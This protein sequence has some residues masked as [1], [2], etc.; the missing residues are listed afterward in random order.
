[1]TGKVRIFVSSVQK[2]LEDE[3]V[4]V[5]HL[6]STDAFL[7]AHCEP[8]L[9]EYE[10]ASAEKASEECLERLDGCR[11][12]VVIVGQKQGARVGS[13]T[14]THME[15]QRAKKGGLP[16]L[17]FIRG[18]RHVSREDGA[19]ALLEEIESDGLKYKRFGNVV[20]LQREVRGSLVQ[21]LESRFGLSPSSDEDQVAEQTIA[22]TSVFESRPLDHVRWSDLDYGMTRRLVAEASAVEEMAL[23]EGEV[24]TGA[25]LRGLVWRAAATGEYYATAAG[26]LL[27]SDDPSAVFPQC[28]ILA[29]A[30]VGIQADS[31]PRDHED[32]REPIPRAVERAVE[33]VER[34]TRHPM[35][36][37]GLKRIRLDE[38]PPEAL[39][40]ALVNALVHRQYEDAGRKILLEV[41]ADKVV[42]SSPGLPPSPITLA[43]LRTGKYRPC[44]RNPVLAQG[45][46]YFQHIEERG[47]GFRRM[48]DRMLDHGLDTPIL[49]TDSGYFQ[50]T[51]LGPG[52]DIERLRTPEGVSVSPAIMASLNDRQRVI[53]E[54]VVESGDVTT[55]WCIE[56]FEVAR[57][58][59][60]RDLVDMVA[61]H[62]L[63]PTGS[64]RSVKYTLATADDD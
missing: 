1:M 22:A 35:R 18:E 37:V 51:L 40:E 43:A 30:Y 33:F 55:R 7:S 60:H 3:R 62:L 13:L 47:S 38:Y 12:Y 36:V 46:S 63:V 32:I 24:L 48:R 44:S 25:A 57:D 20:D 16:V 17:A 5:Q 11:V 19:S 61:L 59:A 53:L 14:I 2:E 21:L 15:Y 50:V 45:L 10:P 27:L 4:I 9:Y 52:E 49:T 29:D 39:R 23:S 64:G 26:V 58:T 42:V 56:R 54:H 34:N 6:L 28:R 41:F 31:T 8:V